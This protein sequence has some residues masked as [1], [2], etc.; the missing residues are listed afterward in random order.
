[1]IDDETYH[2]KSHGAQDIGKYECLLDLQRTEKYRTIL[3]HFDCGFVIWLTNDPY[4]WTQGKRQDTM[5][6]DFAIHSGAVKT[7][8]MAWA[9]HTGLGTMRGREDPITLAKVY[10][11]QWHDYS[12]VSDGRGGQ[13]RYAMFAVSKAREEEKQ[14]G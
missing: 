10:S 1:M 14:S 8:T 11:V 13:L 9:A 4:Y 12:R 3:P 7:G 6:A 5:A 2:L